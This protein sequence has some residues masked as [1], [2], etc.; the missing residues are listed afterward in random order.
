VE[1]E[2]LVSLSGCSF[3]RLILGNF[4]SSLLTE[5]K[6][7]SSVSSHTTHIVPHREKK[8]KGKKSGQRPD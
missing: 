5:H 4:L 6:V 7:C 8:I 2:A 3:A 1:A